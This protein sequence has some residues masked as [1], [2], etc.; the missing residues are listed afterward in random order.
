MMK[1]PFGVIVSEIRP[2]VVV[3]MARLNKIS[4]SG[5]V[6]RFKHRE[7]HQRGTFGKS[8]L[9]VDYCHS[10]PNS[11]AAALIQISAARQSIQISRSSFVGLSL[12]DMCN[13]NAPSAVR[14]SESHAWCSASD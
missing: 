6:V 14:N 9:T 11:S 5:I 1:I 3:L 7:A 2:V 13:R 12:D 10:I 4:V 8:F